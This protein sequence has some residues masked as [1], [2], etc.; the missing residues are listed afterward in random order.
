MSLGAELIQQSNISAAHQFPDEN[1]SFPVDGRFI[2]VVDVK[3]REED[4][5]FI[6]S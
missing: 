6:C 2:V 5:I 1:G 4:L 3:L